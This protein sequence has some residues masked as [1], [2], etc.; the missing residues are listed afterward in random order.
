[1]LCLIQNCI[2]GLFLFIFGLFKQKIQFLQQTNVKQCRSTIRSWDTNPQPLEHESSPIIT[3]PGSHLKIVYN[4]LNVRSIV[5]VY[6]PMCYRVPT[7]V[8]PCT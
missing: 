4:L 2:S 8:L 6:L 5:T 1:M 3:R 7:Y